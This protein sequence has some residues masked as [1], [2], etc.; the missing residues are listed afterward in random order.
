VGR[1]ET[2]V[3]LTTLR[4]YFCHGSKVNPAELPFAWVLGFV[5]IVTLLLLTLTS[6]SSPGRAGTVPGP[7]KRLELGLA[8][9]Y[10]VKSRGGFAGHGITL[11]AADQAGG[12]ARGADLAKYTQACMLSQYA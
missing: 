1:A 10:R 9:V 8:G 5:I 6:T 7:Q 2:A 4:G 3:P 11:R 12:S